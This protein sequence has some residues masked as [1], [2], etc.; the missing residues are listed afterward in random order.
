MAVQF[1]HND[2]TLTLNISKELTGLYRLNAMTHYT[3]V[4]PYMVSA[5][6]LTDKCNADP[7]VI[8]YQVYTVE[9]GWIQISKET[10]EELLKH[11]KV[12]GSKVHT[13][14]R[15]NAAYMS[16]ALLGSMCLLMKFK[17]K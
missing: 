3:A 2:E 1:T 5:H 13:L 10:G 9:K 16:I 11:P 14:N 12:L 15:K 4:K 6:L 17:K 7:N 8:F